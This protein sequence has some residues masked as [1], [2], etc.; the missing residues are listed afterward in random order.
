MLFVHP[1]DVAAGDEFFASTWPEARAIADPRLVLYVAFGLERGGLM[2][3]VGAR[4]LVC[5]IRALVKGNGIGRPVGDVRQMPGAF[6]VRSDRVLATH[7]ATHA[8]DHPDWD[9]MLARAI[10]ASAATD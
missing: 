8:G 6:V 10:D 7:V 2:Q 5:A 1:A 3:F 9:R 4:P